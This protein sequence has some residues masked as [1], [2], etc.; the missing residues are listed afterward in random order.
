M[1]SLKRTYYQFYFA[2]IIF[3]LAPF[4][5]FPQITIKAVGDIMLGSVTPK[6]VLP[7]DSGHI[8]VNE[9][10]SYLKGTDIVFGNFD[11]LV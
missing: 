10:G 8:F 6:T 2:F 7:A 11:F 4:S 9:I 1:I 3:L 5:S